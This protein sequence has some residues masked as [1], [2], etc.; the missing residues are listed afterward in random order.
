MLLSDESAVNKKTQFDRSLFLPD[1]VEIGG[2]QSYINNVQCSDSVF[3]IKVRIVK[4]NGKW[5]AVASHRADQ[6]TLQPCGRRHFHHVPLNGSSWTL[7][8]RVPGHEGEDTLMKRNTSGHRRSSSRGSPRTT[9]TELGLNLFDGR[10]NFRFLDLV[11]NQSH[12]QKALIY[13]CDAYN[14]SVQA[15]Q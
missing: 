4:R 10:L 2:P 9:M 3:E 1:L 15:V 5:L 6:V 8:V 12:L 11:T 14:L 13:T 7:A